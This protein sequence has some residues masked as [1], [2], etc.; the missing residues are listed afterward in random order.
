MTKKTQ[1][2]PV[3]PGTKLRAVGEA[4]LPANAGKLTGRLHAAKAPAGGAID[5][6]LE[7]AIPY[8]LARAGARMMGS[9]STYV[10]PSWCSAAD[11][12]SGGPHI[13]VASCGLSMPDS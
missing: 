3:A 11:L 12:E 1:G 8:L 4:R 2:G 7:R 10:V 13:P 9:F 5:H 6:D